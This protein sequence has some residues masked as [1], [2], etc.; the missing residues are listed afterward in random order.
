[1]PNNCIPEAE[2]GDS[3]FNEA[4]SHY[5]SST[6]ESESASSEGRECSSAADDAIPEMDDVTMVPVPSIN[7]I[8]E[9]MT[10]K[11]ELEDLKTKF[12]ALQKQIQL[13]NE[14]QRENNSRIGF[15]NSHLREAEDHCRD[16]EIEIRQL[17]NENARPV[18]NTQLEDQSATIALLQK[19]LD[20]AR[21]I[22]RFTQLS[23]DDEIRPWKVEDI[24]QRMNWIGSLMKQLLFGHDNIYD[25]DPPDIEND[26][27]LATLVRKCFGMTSQ[28]Q[29]T[30]DT[31]PVRLSDLS[32]QAVVRALTAAALCEWVFETDLHETTLTN[33]ILL[34][35]YRSHIL[36][37]GNYTFQLLF[38]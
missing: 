25:F 31:I 14:L 22:S 37:I 7:I 11:R 26:D 8:N 18:H 38:Y 2:S 3:T 34:D 29:V 19:K 5:S 21:K 20:K 24:R 36:T 9:D 23:Q 35:E 17:K 13:M 33:S 15:L 10:S 4:S 30:A 27:Q 1:M 6:G 16:C 12:E 28:I 32:L